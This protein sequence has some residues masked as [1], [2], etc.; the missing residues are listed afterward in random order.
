[1]VGVEP[2][3]DIAH[4]METAVRSAER[5]GGALP[6]PAVALLIQG[7]SRIT[8]RVQDLSKKRTVRPAPEALIESLTALQWPTAGQ[9]PA[10][11]LRLELPAGILEKITV[12]EAAQLTQA[13]MRG[14]RVLRLDF[15]PSPERAAAGVNI[16]TVRQKLAEVA[17]IVKVLPQARP[18]GPDAQ[19]GLAF[20]LLLCTEAHDEALAHAAGIQAGDIVS[21]VSAAAVEEAARA[22]PGNVVF[23]EE[24]A[25]PIQSGYVRVRVERLDDALERLS[26]LVV[27]EFRL[28]RA[29]A[30]LSAQGVKVSELRRRENNRQL[31]DLRAAIMRARMVSVSKL[32]ERAPLLVRGMTQTTGKKVELQIEA[33]HAEIDKGVGERIFPALLHIIRNAV[34]HA[35]EPPAD[36]VKLGKTEAGHIVISCHERSSTQLELSISDDGRG[37]DRQRVAEKAGCPVPQTDEELLA[38][39]ASGSR[40]CRRPLARADAVSVWTSSRRSPWT[41]RWRP[42]TSDDIR[43]QVQR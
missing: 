36:R 1:M 11:A 42:R 21:A 33:G 4:V 34:D 41:A 24:D 20:V 39:L 31:R 9:Q 22:A 19:A 27:T 13:A 32:L 18:A 28:S 35:I 7:L 23:D 5:S 30:R 2:I 43:E 3:V 37:I 40:R 14:K 10:S 26:A 17:D 12:A 15:V 29:V 16:T 6:A 38:I 25:L 8:E